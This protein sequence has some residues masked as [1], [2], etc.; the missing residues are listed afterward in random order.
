ACLQTGELEQEDLLHGEQEVRI[1]QGEGR[2]RA[3][4]GTRVAAFEEGDAAHGVD[5][6]EG[7]RQ[8]EQENPLPG[9]PQS[10]KG[11]AEVRPHEEDPVRQDSEGVEEDPRLCRE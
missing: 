8:E 4:E 9:S 1:Q 3:Q 6:E 10:R 2:E 5:D 11:G 7:M